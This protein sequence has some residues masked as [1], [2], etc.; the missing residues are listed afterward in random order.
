MTWIGAGGYSLALCGVSWAFFVYA[1][2]RI[3]FW[4]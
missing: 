3:T 1:R 2:G 4:I